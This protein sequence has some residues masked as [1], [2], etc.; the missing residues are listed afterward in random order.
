MERM[1]LAKALV[2]LKLLDQRIQKTRDAFVPVAVKKGGKFVSSK[3]SMTQ[4]AFE[5]ETLADWQKLHGFLDRKKSIKGAI[6]IANATTRLTIAGTEYTLAEAIDMKHAVQVE[7]EILEDAK[8][9]L[10][11]ARNEADRLNKVAAEKLLKLLESM[12]AK[13][14]N[15]LSESD[16]EAVAKPF[17]EAHEA[18]LVDPIGIEKAV[19]DAEERI[20]VFMADVD[21]ALSVCNATTHIEV[22]R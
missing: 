12:Y 4:E 16:H 13:R 22:A 11:A 7:R 14:E 20:D 15:Q 8:D 5:R 18:S 1:T 2:E 21:V 9:K 3:L 19:K 10:S 17:N 6:L